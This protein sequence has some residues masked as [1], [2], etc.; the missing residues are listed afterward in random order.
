LVVV[1]AY[2][3]SRREVASDADQLPGNA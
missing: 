3:T 1:G 2:L